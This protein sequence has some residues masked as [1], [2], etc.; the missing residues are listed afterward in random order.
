MAWQS[1]CRWF[2]SG[3]PAQSTYT[4]AFSS[5]FA[6]R[7]RCPDVHV[8]ARNATWARRAAVNTTGADVVRPGGVVRLARGEPGRAHDRAGVGRQRLAEGRVAVPV[9]DRPGRVERALHRAARQGRRNVAEG[10]VLPAR[11]RAHAVRMAD[12]REYAQ[13]RMRLPY[14]R[15]PSRP[16][17]SRVSGRILSGQSATRGA[18]TGRRVTV[19]GGA[20]LSRGWRGE[21][22][23]CTME[24]PGARAGFLVFFAPAPGP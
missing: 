14:A 13:V 16:W 7:A 10:A 24:S 4:L 12:P 9:G 17:R 11:P 8:Q 20:R 19:R 1:L 23:A 21:V 15:A 3:T 22:D 6:E 2:R 18:A 5:A